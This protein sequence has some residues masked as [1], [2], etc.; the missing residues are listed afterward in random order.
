M[1]SKRKRKSKLERKFSKLSIKREK[2]DGKREKKSKKQIPKKRTVQVPPQD[3]SDGGDTDIIPVEA[4]ESDHTDSDEL[5][6]P[7][8]LT[9]Q[10]AMTYAELCRI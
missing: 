10:N 4:V 2:R 3:E 8:K 6:P 9:R 7:Y 1:A 5:A